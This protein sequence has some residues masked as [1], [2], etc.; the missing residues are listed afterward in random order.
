MWGHVRVEALLSARTVYG[1]CKDV[2]HLRQEGLETLLQ[3]N[4]RYDRIAEEVR[5]IKACVARAGSVEVSF[6][7]YYAYWLLY[8][9]LIHAYLF[10][11]LSLSSPPNVSPYDTNPST[12]SAPSFI[13]STSP[14]SAT[15]PAP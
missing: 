13:S 1:D 6:H 8:I 12:P 4:A 3:A 9:V 2:E 10:T 15:P 11:T 5:V 7:I 14:I